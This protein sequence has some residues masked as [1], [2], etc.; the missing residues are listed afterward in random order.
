MFSKIHIMKKNFFDIHDTGKFFLWVLALPQILMLI[1]EIL[2]IM[3]APIFNTTAEE[4][5]NIPFVYIAL[6]MIAQLAFLM[7]LL[8]YNKKF[9]IKRFAKINL[10][11]GWRNIILCVIIGAVGVFSLSP[12]VDWFNVFLSS[13]G[14]NLSTI[15][16]EI[17]SPLMLILGLVLLAFVPAV[18]EELVFRGVILQGLKKYGK[19]LAIFATSALF[20]LIHGNLQ[21]LIYPFV[22]SIVLGAVVFKTN[23]VVSAIVVHFTSNALTLILSYLG[24][25]LIVPV[26]ASILIAIA[27]ILVMLGLANLTNNTEK[28][29]KAEDILKEI[30]HIQP[31][32]NNNNHTLIIATV[33]AVVLFVCNIAVAFMPA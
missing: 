7:V 16:F 2:L 11:L 31:T 32:Y 15:G 14:F 17:S 26:W 29:R 19:W 24:F 13:I 28:P 23:S 25:T 6:G 8:L 3:L 20:M 10:S 1:A 27:G 30:D 18:L 12:L 9:N 4:A 33:L 21:Q 5:L 22:L